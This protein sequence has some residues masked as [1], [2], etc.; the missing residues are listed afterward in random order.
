MVDRRSS[1]VTS[2]TI[3]YSLPSTTFDIPHKSFLRS[4]ERMRVTGRWAGGLCDPE[5]EVASRPTQ[6]PVWGRDIFLLPTP[7]SMVVRVLP[8]AF[9][10]F[11]CI[12]LIQSHIIEW[13]RTHSTSAVWHHSVSGGAEMTRVAQPASRDGAKAAATFLTRYARGTQGWYAFFP[14]LRPSRPISPFRFPPPA[15]DRQPPRRAWQPN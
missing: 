4:P 10:N 12:L 8:R 11:I 14:R 13:A 9:A 15:L 5:V 3:K 7:I 6:L 1:S 2:F